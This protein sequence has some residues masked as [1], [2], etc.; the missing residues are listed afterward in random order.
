MSPVM[1]GLLA[2]CVVK[3]ASPVCSRAVVLL[4]EGRL[5][6]DAVAADIDANFKVFNLTHVINPFIASCSKL[7]LFEGFSTILV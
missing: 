3:Y 1:A 5:S 7:L 6:S 4:L 2:E